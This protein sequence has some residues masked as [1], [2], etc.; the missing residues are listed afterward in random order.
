V[1]PIRQH[2]QRSR[3]ELK[4]LIDEPRARQVRDFTRCYLRRDPHAKADLGFLYPIYSLYFDDAG[5]ML[6]RATVQAQKNRFKMR[7]RYYDHKPQSPLFCEIKRRVNDVIIKQR[8]VIKRDALDRLVH[9]CCPRMD[10]LHDT[11]DVDS[12][13]TLRE[14]CA[15]RDSLHAEPNIIV[16]FRREA[17]VSTADENVRVTF[18]RAAAVTRYTPT[19]DPEK[20]SDARINQVILELKF[21]D[22]FPV[23]MREMVQCCDLHR[24]QMGKYVHC[25]DQLPRRDVRPFMHMSA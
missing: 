6:Y 12:Y 21:D 19:L 13:S 23:W 22:R 2:Y 15:L 14:F 7:V 16:Y 8:A 11:A 17:W 5:L 10:D 24:T 3:Y 25:L 1:L 20:W 9:G 18:D 4:Y